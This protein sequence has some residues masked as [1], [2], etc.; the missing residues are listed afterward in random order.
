V[1][2]SNV[3]PLHGSDLPVAADVAEAEF[4]KWVRAMGMSQKLDP[5]RLDG[6]DRKSLLDQ[7]RVITDAIERGELVVNDEGCFEFTPT[8]G[9]TIAWPEP[10]MEVMMAID[11]HRETDNAKRMFFIMAKMTGKPVT[12]FRALKLR[13]GQVCQAVANLFL[14]S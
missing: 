10:T 4:Q 8:G 14:A 12:F 11:G 5:S 9:Q 13:H 2:V 3:V 1:S 7:K 6:E